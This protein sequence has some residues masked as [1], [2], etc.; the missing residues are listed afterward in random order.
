M[1]ISI[2]PGVTFESGAAIVYDKIPPG[3]QEF[4]EPGTYSFVVP[5]GVT[6]INAVLIGGGGG[7]DNSLGSGQLAGGGGGLRW[8][9]RLPVT[10]GETL[11]VVVGAGGVS[12]TGS[13]SSTPGGNS[14]LRRATNQAVLV[15]AAGGRVAL[16]GSGG[17]GTEIGFGPYGGVVGGGDGGNID[18]FGPWGGGGAG[19]YS[20]KGGNGQ[21]LSAGTILPE[22]GQGGGGG[23]GRQYGGAGGGVGIY[24]QGASGEPGGGTAIFGQDGRSGQGGSG[25]LPL[26]SDTISPSGGLYGG[27]AGAYRNGEA[28]AEPY[29]GGH[30]AVRIIWGDG[31]AFPS[32]NTGDL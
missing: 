16:I 25:G 8:I 24:G 9:N 21:Q 23:G 1:T 22:P 17:A 11:E 2:E 14:I 5:N 32:T 7:A 15:M 29:T 27:G 6:V 26:T 4:I 20:G 18:G 13:G 12:G 19:G 10:P 28:P 3:Q 30:G 31:R